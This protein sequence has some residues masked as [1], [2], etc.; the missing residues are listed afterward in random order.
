MIRGGLAAVAAATVLVVCVP[1]CNGSFRF[2]EGSVDGGSEAGASTG[3]AAALPECTSDAPCAPL[4]MR[5][6]TESRVCVACLTDAECT[7]AGR[8]FCEPKQHVCVACR[9]TANCPSRHTCEPTTHRCLDACFDDDDLC[10]IQGFECNQELRLC[11]ECRE[12]GHCEASPRGKRCNVDSGECVAC[13]TKEHCA[14]PRPTCDP[15]SGT[16]VGCVTTSD[17][18]P[19]QACAPA[20]QTC[21]VVVAP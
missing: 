14:A 17:C 8:R 16:C 11:V 9:T 19:G 6:D 5:C 2:D 20:T 3:D 10:P 18:A 4:G 21:E 15:R 12:D 7:S 1:A 13:V